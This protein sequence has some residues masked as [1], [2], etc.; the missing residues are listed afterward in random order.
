ME[1]LLDILNGRVTA[2]WDETAI[3][4]L[5]KEGGKDIVAQ[6]SAAEL[7]KKGI[8]KESRFLLKSYETENGVRFDFELIEPRKLSQE[9]INAIHA[10]VSLEVNS[11][12]L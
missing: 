5:S 4:L 2:V 7:E 12:W 10:S 6:W 9:E 1:T 8:R 11:T 3:L